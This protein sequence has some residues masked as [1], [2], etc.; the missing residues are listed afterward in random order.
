MKKLN[1]A[2]LLAL[3]VVGFGLPLASYTLNYLNRYSLPQLLMQIPDLGYLQLIYLLTLVFIVAMLLRRW[4]LGRALLWPFKA[5]WTVLHWLGAALWALLRPSPIGFLSGWK[6]FWLLNR[7]H[8]GFLLD[9][10]NKHLSQKKSF[11][12]AVSVG[13]V[14]T[15]KSTVQVIPNLLTLENCSMVVTDVSGELYQATSGHLAKKG[16]NIQVLNLMDTSRS[17]GYNP[18]HNPRTT[19][20]IQKLA[21]LLVSSGE[22]GNDPFWSQGAE[23]IMGI[24]MQC[25]KNRSQ[26]RGETDTCNLANLRYLLNNFDAHLH[27]PPGQIS[28]LDRFV[29]ES[30]L[31]DR[32]TFNEY[33]GFTT[34]TNDKTMLSFLSTANT[35]LSMLSNTDVQQLTARHE[36]DFDRL[37]KQKTVIYVMVKQ[38][39]F[40][41]YQFLVSA[42]FT[43]LIHHLLQDLNSSHLPTYLLLDEFGSSM[44]IPGFSTFA[45]TARK[46]KVGFWLFLQ[47]LSQLEARYDKQEAET[48]LDSLASEMY[49]PGQSID[50]ASRLQ[51]RLGS[52]YN[53][54]QQRHQQL[55]S[56]TQIIEMK[57][58]ELLLL[59]G[60]KRPVKLKTKPFYKRSDMKRWCQAGAAK[61]PTS[62]TAPLQWVDLQSSKPRVRVPPA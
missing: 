53:T 51:R 44:T 54:E 61:L 31:N 45:A 9:G 1:K 60:N 21:H 27:Q 4:Q 28:K 42:F 22:T 62:S 59:H 23:R 58:D 2:I 34:A 29:M 7:W 6:S 57:D 20:E 37:R 55:M 36:F 52:Q 19:T 15:G 8:K 13:G 41:Y 30:T 18:L 14:G 17:L 16:F 39:D 3:V 48:I 40:N 33:K 26:E 25:L 50:T 35:S 38:Q 49:F 43:D 47:S 5:I 56:E 46:Y 12:S 10:K 11:Q 24:L 32:S